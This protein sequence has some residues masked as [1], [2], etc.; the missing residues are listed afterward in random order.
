MDVISNILL[1][2]LQPWS[3]FKSGLNSNRGGT[4]GGLVLATPLEGGKL[5]FEDFR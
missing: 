1:F 4:R 2:M 5:F 3:R